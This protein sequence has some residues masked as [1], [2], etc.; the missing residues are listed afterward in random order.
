M[1]LGQKEGLP[2][3]SFQRMGRRSPGREGREDLP[4]SG[5]GV[6]KGLE[7]VKKV[8]CPVLPGS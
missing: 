6:S 4:E 7:A 5:D 8:A 3:L 1:G 2:E